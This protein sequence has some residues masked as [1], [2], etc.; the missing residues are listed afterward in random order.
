[1]KILIEN[2]AARWAVIFI[3]AVAVGCTAPEQNRQ[4]M[5]NVDGNTAVA[6]ASPAMSAATTNAA[7][8]VSV[9]HSSNDYDK[10]K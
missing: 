9:E 4:T 8:I 1:M 7:T 5:G 10:I 6:V 3:I 2:S